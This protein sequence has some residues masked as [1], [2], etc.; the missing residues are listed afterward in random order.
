MGKNIANP[1]TLPARIAT[2][3]SS[4]AANINITD[5]ILVPRVT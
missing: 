1:K 3:G 2:I 5:K 4:D